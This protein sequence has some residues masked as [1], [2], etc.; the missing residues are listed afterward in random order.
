MMSSEDRL[1][2]GRKHCSRTRRVRSR[3]AAYFH[4]QQILAQVLHLLHCCEICNMRLER[5]M[6]LGPLSGLPVIQ[7]LDIILQLHVTDLV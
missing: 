1:L 7:E 4:M 2:G 6:S 3:T 5:P